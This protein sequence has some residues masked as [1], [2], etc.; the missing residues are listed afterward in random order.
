MN[1][2]RKYRPKK[3]ADLHLTKVREHFLAL[4]KSG[5]FSQVFLFAGPKGTGKTST[6]RIV[7]ALLNDPANEAAVTEIFFKKSGKAK[8]LQEP[9]SANERIERIFS[10]SSFMVQELDAASNRGIDDI[11]AL[12]ERVSLPPQDGLMSVYILD[13]VHMLTT[14]AFNALLKILEEPPPH[15]VFI[16]ATT[17]LDKIPATVTSRA[18]VISFTKATPAELQNALTLILDQEKATYEQAVLEAIAQQADGSFRDAVKLLE[19][20][21]QL[22]E[23]TMLKAEQVLS[24]STLHF[25]TQLVEALLAKDAA[26]VVTIFQ[27]LR[28]RMTDQ[29]QFYTQ[30]LTLLHTDLLKAHGVVPGT[31]QWPAK[32]SHFM[33]KELSDPFVQVITPILLLPLELKFLDIIERSHKKNVSE[34]SGPGGS[35]SKEPSAAKA[36][37]AETPRSSAKSAQGTH[38]SLGFDPEA[39]QQLA[40]VDSYSDMLDEGSGFARPDEATAPQSSSQLHAVSESVSARTANVS[41][42]TESSTQGTSRS[43]MSVTKA[44]LGSAKSTTPLLPTDP[45]DGTIICDKWVD[46]VAAAVKQNFGLATL[47]RSA[48]PIS[49][50]MGRIVVS[51]YYSFHKEQ[52]MQPKF[53][54]LLD[55]LFADY[56][57]GRIELECILEAQPSHAELQ[58]APQ[59]NNLAE[60]AVASLM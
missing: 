14:E 15:V 30:L 13:E 28:E 48:K 38:H 59:S 55:V 57:G 45:G 3:I 54:Q 37:P 29:K 10:G 52:L 24:L 36:G 47:L 16:L 41:L 23:I 34:P 44:S 43:S 33:L 49:G 58:E 40:H 18:Q 50:E 21:A 56:A 51:V 42:S 31:A 12:K 4:L 27:A 1:W 22:G 46:V 25:T 20:V 26:Q 9:N 19:M 2:N 8:P 6:A 7:A 53:K 11:R 39:E 5:K 32:A 60:L 17:E 35:G